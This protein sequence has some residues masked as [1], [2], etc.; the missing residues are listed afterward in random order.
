MFVIGYFYLFDSFITSS[1]YQALFPSDSYEAPERFDQFNCELPP[2]YW[3]YVGTQEEKILW[4]GK[5]SIS[6][7]I[8]IYKLFPQNIFEIL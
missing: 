3:Y 4:K 1:Y 7:K 6:F 2:S 5:T 8:L